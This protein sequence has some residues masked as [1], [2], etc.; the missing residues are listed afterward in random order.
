MA[1][2]K[3]CANNHVYDAD[4]YASC[5][6]CSGQGTSIRFGAASD[7]GKTVLPGIGN[8]EKLG[9]TVA[10]ASYLENEKRK[11]K[12]VG[13]YKKQNALDPVVGW[14]VCVEG[15]D[16]GKSFE[17]HPQVNVI[18]RGEDADVLLQDQTVSKEQVKLGYDVK[19][20]NFYLIPADNKNTTYLNDMPLYVPT[21]VNPYDVIEAGESKLMFIPFC[22]EKF[23]WSSE[24]K[25]GD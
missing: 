12:T 20:N 24:S 11:G 9:A 23:Q 14:I 17:L 25:Q 3:R 18:G 7:S 19:H 6:Y 16:K 10:P 8:A 13:V 15:A 4:I 5:P 21:P 22:G 2:Q 1:N